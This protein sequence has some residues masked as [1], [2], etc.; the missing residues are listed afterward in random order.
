MRGDDEPFKLLVGVIG[1]RE[2]D[3]GRA[4]AGLAGGDFDAAHD[5]VGPG[6]GGNLQSVA[7]IG[8]ANDCLRQINRVR[9]QRHAHRVY[10]RSGTA[11]ERDECDGDEQKSEPTHNV[12]VV[13][14]ARAAGL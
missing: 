6:R 7:L 3:P 12:P 1:E 13:S 2:H 5:A 14:A 9:V 4:R 11:C 10:R 8:I